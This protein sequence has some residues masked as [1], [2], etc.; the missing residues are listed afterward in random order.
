MSTHAALE[1][2][3]KRDDHRRGPLN[4][5]EAGGA[6]MLL[7]LRTLRSAGGGVSALVRMLS[8]S[9][10]LIVVREEEE[11]AGETGEV[12]QIET[13]GQGRLERKQGG[14]AKQRDVS[15]DSTESLAAAVYVDVLRERF[16][17]RSEE[18]P[19]GRP[20]SLCSCATSRRR[21]RDD[22]EP[23]G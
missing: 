16:G 17:G 9:G 6:E 1:K 12:R 8:C 21:R 20:R 14:R 3:Q 10:L 11:E 7:P 19:V 18:G 15:G 22:G 23:C 5:L 2:I 4:T 13:G